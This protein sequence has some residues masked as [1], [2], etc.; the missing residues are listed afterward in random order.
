[1]LPRLFFYTLFQTVYTPR[2]RFYKLGVRIFIRFPFTIGIK[3]IGNN[4][5]CQKRCCFRFG[6]GTIMAF[7]K[8]QY[9]LT[10]LACCS[11]YNF[12]VGII[13]HNTATIAIPYP[14]FKSYITHSFIF[15][16]LT[17]SLL[18]HLGHR[19]FKV[20]STVAST[21]ASIS[22]NLCLHLRQYTL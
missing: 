7:A 18:P 12:S 8:H 16:I 3:N 22:S 19:F 13:S 1:M 9:F 2:Q 6:I 11:I 20:D 21:S 4:V 15:G 14:W 17:K 10:Q 5:Y